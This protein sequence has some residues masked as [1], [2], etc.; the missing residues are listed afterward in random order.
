MAW[1]AKA[2]R[3]VD[4]GLDM[5]LMA[6]KHGKKKQLHYW[7]KH[8]DLHGW[9]QALFSRQSG[10]D[11]AWEFN[12]EEVPLSVADLDKLQADVEMEAL[13]K[14]D[15]FFFGDSSWKDHKDDDIDA[16]RKAREAIKDGWYVFYDSSW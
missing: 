9:M 15:G 5:Y 3:G 6:A 16:I 1:Q 13:P 14:T 10:L 12:G 8:P 2:N 4:M 11:N 7:R